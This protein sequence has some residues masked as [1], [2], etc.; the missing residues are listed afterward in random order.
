ML[1]QMPV[2][3]RNS[4]LLVL[5]IGCKKPPPG[6][7]LVLDSPAPKASASTDQALEAACNKREPLACN[8]L[9]VTME[10]TDPIRAAELY[11]RA[12]EDGTASGCNNL[13]AL[14]AD[15]RGVPKDDA[16]AAGYFS[17]G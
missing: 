15:G 10:K 3:T 14:Y 9:G 2:W 5:A 7:E 6:A 17:R 12:C 4:L 13:A 11:R 8:D 1:R 16:R